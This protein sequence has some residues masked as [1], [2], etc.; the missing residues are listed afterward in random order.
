MRTTNFTDFPCGRMNEVWDWV[1]A[2]DAFDYNDREPLTELVKRE[3]VPEEL[4]PI[5]AE[6]VRGSRTPNLKA[7]AKLKIPAAER[8][9]IA[10][11]VSTV[12]G[13]I[14]TLKFDAID[15]PTISAR[16]A[17]AFS[18]RFGREPNEIIRE[19]EAKAR[20]VIEWAAG[21]LGVSKETVES[22][23]RDLRRKAK[24]FPNL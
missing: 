17:S 8:M 23:L 14:D 5:I 19:L 6:I 4:R 13:L 7:A 2:I 22:L 12:L 20:D 3:P 18:E 24:V 15:D 11:S 21:E 16:G 9:K 1:C 10:G